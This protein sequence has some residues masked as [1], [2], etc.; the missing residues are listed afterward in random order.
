LDSRDSENTKHKPSLFIAGFTLFG[1]A[2]VI[3]VFA[4]VT[5]LVICVILQ[6]LGLELEP[7]LLWPV[8]GLNCCLL[9]RFF[10][11]SVKEG[12]KGK[13]DGQIASNKQI[14]ELNE[15]IL[16]SKILSH[17]I[18]IGLILSLVLLVY[19]IIKHYFG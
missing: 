1:F 12:L 15:Y 6:V 4:S 2:L 5:T 8:Y 13:T 11:W 3:L 18:N 17:F 16:T 9:S 7:I 14:S 10:L 19:A